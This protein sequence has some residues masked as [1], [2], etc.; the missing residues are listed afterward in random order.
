MHN[1]FPKDWMAQSGQRMGPIGDELNRA[2]VLSA[3]DCGGIAQCPQDF[4]VQYLCSSDDL[5]HL[6]LVCIQSLQSR[7]HEIAELRPYTQLALQAPPSTVVDQH[8]VFARR[9]EQTA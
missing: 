9:V 3:R 1:H 8:V 6:E 7:L 4:P 5:D 2:A